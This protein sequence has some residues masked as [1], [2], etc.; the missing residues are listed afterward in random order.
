MGHLSSVSGVLIRGGE[1]HAATRQLSD[2]S[3]RIKRMH[4]QTEEYQD[5]LI[6]PEAIRGKEWF[7][8]IDVRRR[9]TLMSP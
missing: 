7:S 9:M 3:C 4:V 1:R 2:N 8:P 5:L 6:L